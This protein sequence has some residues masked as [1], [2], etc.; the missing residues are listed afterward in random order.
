MPCNLN[1]TYISDPLRTYRITR[2]S[3]VTRSSVANV[4]RYAPAF[5]EG[6][7]YDLVYISF[8]LFESL[9]FARNRYIEHVTEQGDGRVSGQAAAAR[10]AAGCPAAKRATAQRSA[11]RAA[12]RAATETLRSH[13]RRCHVRGSYWSMAKPLTIEACTECFGTNLNLAAL[14]S[15]PLAAYTRRRIKDLDLSLSVPCTYIDICA[16]PTLIK[17]SDRGGIVI[18]FPGT[19]SSDICSVIDIFQ[20]ARVYLT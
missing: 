5:I 9:G 4:H 13:P 20:D 18:P 15:S 8:S 10:F 14:L 6:R 3:T 2:W 16:S 1:R 19:I 17:T 7:N 11:R 12:T